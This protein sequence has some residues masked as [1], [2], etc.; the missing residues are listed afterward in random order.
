MEQMWQLEKHFSIYVDRKKNMVKI[1][2]LA[3][4]KPNKGN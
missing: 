2:D 3:F 4:W 1:W